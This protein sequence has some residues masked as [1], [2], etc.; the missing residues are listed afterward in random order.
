MAKK[1][2]K[3]KTKATAKKTAAKKKTAKKTAKKA[4]ARKSAVST[5]ARK[6]APVPAKKSTT[7]GKSSGKGDDRKFRQLSNVEHVRMR[8]GMWLGQNSKATV[9]QHF[10]VNKRSGYEIEH[11]E[12]EIIPAVWKC[13]DET[14]MN[15]IDEY[16]KNQSDKKVKPKDRMNRL[17]VVL[18]DDRK[19]VTVTDNGRGIPMDN[20]EGVYLHLM[21]GENFDDLVQQDH[22]AGQNGVGV[23]LVRM[24]SE[25]FRVTSINGG[26]EYQRRFTA[27]DSFKKLLGTFRLNQA[28]QDA[29]LLYFDEHGHVNDTPLL[30]DGQKEK[31]VKL[32]QKNLM[33]ERVKK[34]ACR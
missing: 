1:K 24:V 18:S 8:T 15:T 33:T 2:A 10:F 26:R 17:E 13:L 9:S 21:Y 29:V 31:C 7:G 28:D 27:D 6:K 22:V 32:M 30:T 12:V 11:E 5:A 19:T 14:C 20:V 25:S 16:R 34:A 3:K 23:S 4:P